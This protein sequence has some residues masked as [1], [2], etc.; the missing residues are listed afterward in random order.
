MEWSVAEGARLF[1]AALRREEEQMQSNSKM[2]GCPCIHAYTEQL[3]RADLAMRR[4][5]EHFAPHRDPGAVR[6]RNV[7]RAYLVRAIL[8]AHNIPVL[9]RDDEHRSTGP[10]GDR[11][12]R[13]TGRDRRAGVRS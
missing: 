7:A 4:D 6:A 8:D 2:H 13:R 1:V 3:R 12:D 5:D 10:D 11:L 9:P